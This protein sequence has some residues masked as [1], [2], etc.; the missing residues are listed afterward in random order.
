MAITGRALSHGASGRG[1]A[2]GSGRDEDEIT[3]VAKLA[4]TPNF[5]LSKTRPD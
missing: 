1:R 4:A 2:I 5:R 3:G